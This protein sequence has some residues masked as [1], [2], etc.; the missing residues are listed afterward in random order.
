M[1]RLL[2]CL[3]ALIAL[4]LLPA[5]A[6]AAPAVDGEFDV[7]PETPGRSTQGPDGNVWV[8]LSGP[9]D[10]AKVTPNGDVQKFDVA[11][12]AGATDIT[13]GPDGN[14]WVTTTAGVAK[15]SPGNPAAATSF[16][17]ANLATAQGI[18]TGP[19]N[20]LWVANANKVY[21]VPPATP[22]TP[23]PFP[24]PDAMASAR[25]IAS[26]GGLLW[27]A[28][29]GGKEIVSVTTAA[30]HDALRGRRHGTAGSHG[31]PGN[32]DRLHESE[33]RARQDLPGR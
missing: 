33:Q 25:G 2:P 20:N 14:L 13:V 11:A 32:S 30:G 12:L 3:L 24:L 9:N 26:S 18:T 17:E 31:R 16:T 4:A 1:R 7:A 23:T 21:R 22:T 6:S 19:D 10:V 27:V 29:F 28:D 8:V 15:F 5:A